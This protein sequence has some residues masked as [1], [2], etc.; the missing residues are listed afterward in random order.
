MDSG[1]IGLNVGIEEENIQKHLDE[2]GK[3]GRLPEGG[4]ARLAYS[5]EESH[6]PDEYTDTKY[7]V[8]ATKV[9]ALTLIDLYK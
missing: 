2:L 3:I 9:L 6:G 8:S 7:I 4:Y 1:N 5:P